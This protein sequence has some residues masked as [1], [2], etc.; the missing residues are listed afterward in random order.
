MPRK[1][2][3][4]IPVA[5]IFAS[6]ATTAQSPPPAAD[7]ESQ[8]LSIGVVVQRA[9][10]PVLYVM[11]D[12]TGIDAVDLRT[13]TLLWHSAH[14]AAPLLARGTE[15]LALA[16]PLPGKTEGRLFVLETRT[17]DVRSQLPDLQVNG[18]RVVLEQDLRT[19]LELYGCVRGGRDFLVWKAAT[20]DVSPIPHPARGGQV[21]RGAVEVDLARG[22]LVPTTEVF[23]DRFLTMK[24]DGRGGSVWEAFE[25]GAVR[26]TVAKP[27]RHNAYIILLRR[28]RGRATL[29]DVILAKPPTEFWNPE[30]SVD[31]HHVLVAYYKTERYDVTAFNAATGKRLG[32]VVIGSWPAPFLIWDHLLVWYAPSAVRVADFT[33]GKTLFAHAVRGLEYRGPYPPGATPP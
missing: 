11:N 1:H 19:S 26:V 33:S 22:T 32:H 21:V 29:P 3:S 7:P 6:G 31:R 4:L 9:T 10:P 16:P 8:T 23:P 28:A 12:T 25:T 15:L 2:V 14:A 27:I 17:G 5:L 24:S 13:G 20:R 18:W 30:V